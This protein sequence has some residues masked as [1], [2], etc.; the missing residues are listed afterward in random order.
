MHLESLLNPPTDNND[1]VHDDY[2][3][4]VPVLDDPIIIKEENDVIK[5]RVSTVSTQVFFRWF[6]KSR[7]SI[8]LLL[9]NFVLS[10]AN[11]GVFGVL[12]G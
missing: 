2:N 6:P 11:T 10:A 3:M 4:N 5:L 12:Q 8:L 9:L 7:I 1:G